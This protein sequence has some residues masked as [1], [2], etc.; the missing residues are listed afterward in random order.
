MRRFRMV[1]GVA[2]HDPASGLRHPAGDPLAHGDRRV[3]RGHVAVFRGAGPVQVDDLEPGAVF[4]HQE[5]PALVVRQHGADGFADAIA[6]V[7][8][9]GGTGKVLSKGFDGLHVLGP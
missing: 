1:L 5:H 7:L 9:G 2:D 8:D 6:N 4:T 3:L